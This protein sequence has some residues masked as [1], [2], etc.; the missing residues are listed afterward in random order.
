MSPTMLGIGWGIIA[1]WWVGLLLGIPLAVAARAGRCT[2]RSAWS[3]TRPVVS[4]LL[5][6]AACALLAGLVGY[7]L[8]RSGA[9]Y[10]SEPM[11][12]LVPRDRHAP[13]QADLWAHLASYLVGFVGGIVVIVRVWSRSNPPSVRPWL[14]RSSWSDRSYFFLVDASTKSCL[15][16][17]AIRT[18]D[19]RSRPSPRSHRSHRWRPASMRYGSSSPDTVAISRVS[20]GRPLRS[21]WPPAR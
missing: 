16:H 15:V 3:L 9:V 14:R 1:T 7:A 11:A 13:F 21:T 19:T 18:F 10:L 20:P 6:M 8:G 4:L 2:K 12:S 5:V 17:F